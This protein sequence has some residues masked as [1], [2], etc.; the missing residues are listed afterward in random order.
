MAGLGI[1]VFPCIVDKSPQPWHRRL[2]LAQTHTCAELIGCKR[3]ATEHWKN[4]WCAITD[5]LVPNKNTELSLV[6]GWPCRSGE[7]PWLRDGIWQVKGS[8]WTDLLFLHE[9]KK[10]KWK[11][12]KNEEKMPGHSSMHWMC[13]CTVWLGLQIF[14]RLIPPPTESCKANSSWFILMHQDFINPNLWNTDLLPE[15]GILKIL[16]SN[17]VSFP[18]RPTSG[19]GSDA[20]LVILSQPTL[21]YHLLKHSWASFWYVFGGRQ[22]GGTGNSAQGIVLE[23]APAFEPLAQSFML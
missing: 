4:S 8:Y 20:L 13:T 11:K 15:D 5:T 16:S 23:K 19:L 2:L 14:V 10:K 1:P 3:K 6:W 22:G 17:C 9:I 7:H 18:S 12:E 21:H